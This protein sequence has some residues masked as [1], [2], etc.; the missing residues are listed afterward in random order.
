MKKRRNHH[1]GGGLSR[2]LSGRSSARC[3]TREWSWMKRGV[4]SVLQGIL[5]EQKWSATKKWNT[6]EAGPKRDG[7]GAASNKHLIK[8]LKKSPLIKDSP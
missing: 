4:V 6:I 7:F 8:E 5:R 3:R 1:D 2:F